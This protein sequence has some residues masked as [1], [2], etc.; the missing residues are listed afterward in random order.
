MPEKNSKGTQDIYQ[1]HGYTSE[2]VLEEFKTSV[3]GLDDEEVLARLDTHGYNELTASDTNGFLGILL[4]QF[5]SVLVGILVIAAVISYTFDH[6]VDAYVIAVI[7]ILNAILGFTQEYRAQKAISSLKKILVLK[8][9]VLRHK[10]LAEVPARELVPGDIIVLEAG[11]LIPADA[12]LIEVSDFE[13]NE[14]SLTGESL[15]VH[16]HV[17]AL[18]KSTALSDRANMV[19]MGT[20]VTKG[21]ARAMVVHT[22][23]KTAIGSIATMLD[24]VED[25]E[26]HFKKNARKLALQLGSLAFVSASIVFIVGYFFR[27]IAFDEIFLFTVASLVSG[28]PE[29][30]PA[31]LSI[32][33]AVGAYRMSKHGALVRTL[34]ATETLGVTSVIVTDK[35]GTLTQNVMMVENIV[36]NKGEGNVQVTGVRWEPK[37]EFTI[38]E[39]EPIA[40]LE[41]RSLAKLL[42]IAGKAASAHI[43]YNEEKE[44]YS[45]LGDPTEAA[46]TVVAHKAGLDESILFAHEKI[47]HEI[48]FSSETKWR[49]ILVELREH[50]EGYDLFRQVY[51]MGAPEVLLSV[52]NK[53]LVDGIEKRLTDKDR[54]NYLAEM[55]AMSQRALRVIGLTYK[56]L[57]PDSQH[58]SEQDVSDMVF[59]GFVGMKDP[60]HSDVPEA[61]RQAKL[62]GV[63]VIMATGDH[64]TTALAIAREIGLLDGVE[65]QAGPQVLTGVEL[66]AMSDSE[67]NSA[68][69]TVSIFARLEPKTKLRIS[70]A[71][72]SQGH[73][74][75]MTG[76]GVN[77]ALA[78]KQADI[79]IAMGQGGTDVARQSSDIIL[80]QDNFASIIHAIREGRTVFSNTR[81]SATFLVTTSLAEHATILGTM[82]AGLPLPLLPTQILWLNLVTDGTAG[83]PL[84]LE[85]SRDDVL[86]K[87]PRKKEENIL[88]YQSIPF[89]LLVVTV[90]FAG[91]FLVFTMFLPG[92]EDKA[93]TGAFAVMA[94]TQIFNVLNVRSLHDSLFTVGLWTNRPIIYAFVFSFVLTIGA[95]YIPF[96]QNIFKFVSLTAGELIGIILLSSCVLWFGEVYKFARKHW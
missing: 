34:A 67:F 5:K 79:G 55:E 10:E 8:A 74:V 33:L 29:G 65:K 3:S 41:D 23:D 43:V 63:R 51:A 14:S 27:D 30:L 59:V 9:N 22:G 88:D 84:A 7:I 83:V 80:T 87:K 49:A 45:A 17:D 38:S 53:H 72:Q 6:Y 70:K 1:A 93:R 40:P 25:T 47:L 2:K 78:L 28:I 19:W 64:K 18:S 12:R 91:T 11:M 48:P 90:M 36:Y 21:T 39:G 95:L 52:A 85:P 61:I 24:N 16:K 4:S 54:E 15:P 62:A 94:F 86:K 68:L 35:T 60:I 50:G 32:V 46:L 58:V 81:R 71:F 82:V 37:G 77:D 31:I 73:I 56:N 96:T 92:G 57:P 66:Q 76:D 89:L 75:A 20:V 42:H 26:T 44:E 13:T 69:K